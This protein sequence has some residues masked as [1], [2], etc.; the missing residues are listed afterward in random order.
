[1]N[2]VLNYLATSVIAVYGF[3][4][5]TIVAKENHVGEE[6]LPLRPRLVYFL[7]A[8]ISRRARVCCRK[9]GNVHFCLVQT[10]PPFTAAL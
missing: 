6:A 3:S 5:S 9:V 8:A 10:G 4:K 7:F 2:T 1:M